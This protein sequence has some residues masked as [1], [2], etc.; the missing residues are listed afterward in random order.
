M[1]RVAFVDPRSGPLAG[2]EKP[3]V[4]MATDPSDLT[5][6]RR[7]CKE[8]RLYEVE[9]WIQAG[10][11]LQLA[12]GVTVRGR[13][14][15]SALRVALESGS[16]ALALLFLCNGYD[17]NLEPESPLNL[18]LRY[19]RRD[20]LDLLLDWGAD[21]HQVCRTSLFDT[22][23][24][25][26]FERFR[27]MGVD[28]C[29][30]HELAET[31]AYH[32]SN[33]PLFGFA[34]R[35][36]ERDP[37]FQTELNAAL[38]YHAGK[39]NEKGVQLCLWAGADPHAPAPS[40]RY[41]SYVNEDDEEED[42]EGRFHG[43]S[44]VHEACSY[45]RADILRRLEPD[46]TRDDFEELYRWAKTGSIIE[47]LAERE[48]PEE[49]G[50]LISHHLLWL[51]FDREWRSLGVIRTLF[52]VGVR[53]RKSPK[54]EIANVRSI[55]LKVSDHRLVDLMKLLATDEYCS[56]EV[57]QELGR[58]PA[59]RRRM[60]EVGF[61][62]PDPDDRMQRRYSRPTRSREILSKFGVEL[63]KPPPYIPRVVEIGAWRNEGR[64]IRLDRAGLFERVWS[65]PMVKL[66]K[67][68]GLSDQGLRKACR[69][70]QIQLPPR[71]YWAKLASGKRMR[72]PKLRELKEGEAEEIVIR[73]PE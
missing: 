6:L 8:G 31:L 40:L 52:K 29:E 39:G 1:P 33:K 36:R 22:Y 21:P 63:P 48:H 73:L 70:V 14:V 15:P 67:E 44:A 47:I 72:R 11:S 9:R 2:S 55:F 37:L 34:K 12:Q 65:K 62:P 26:L 32:T 30:G 59:M 28:L 51:R 46:P 17:P 68:W 58:P 25:A 23:D 43:F 53:W 24:S 49:V 5:D 19:R 60:K 42:E 45:G 71:G 27:L 56:P 13:P 57:L 20:L 69:R 54:G 41:S 18:A 61:I 4:R 7:L 66:A 10:R 16:Y 38:A 50:A 35:H 64:E 3:S